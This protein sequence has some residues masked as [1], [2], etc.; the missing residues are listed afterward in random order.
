MPLIHVKVTEVTFDH[1]NKL[2]AREISKL[3]KKVTDKVYTFNPE[4]YCDISSVADSISNDTGWCVYDLEYVAE[5][6]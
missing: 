3:T 5:L 1:D 4:D 6:K 2:S